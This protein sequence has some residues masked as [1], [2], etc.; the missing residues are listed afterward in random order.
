MRRLYLV[1]AGASLISGIAC[2]TGALDLSFLVANCA[3]RSTSSLDFAR[4]L[5]LRALFLTN[6]IKGSG[7]VLG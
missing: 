1:D 6:S 5:S 7:G 3:I 2:A 4:A